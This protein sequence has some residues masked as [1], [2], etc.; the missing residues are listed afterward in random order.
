MPWLPLTRQWMQQLVRRERTEQLA[1]GKRR[2]HRP[3]GQLKGQEGQGGKEDHQTSPSRASRLRAGNISWSNCPTDRRGRP[4]P[5]KPKKK[6]TASDTLRA[7]RTHI[8]VEAAKR[9]TAPHGIHRP[10][11]AMTRTAQR[12]RNR[13]RTGLRADAGGWAVGTHFVRTGQLLLLERMRSFSLWV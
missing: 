13:P 3:Q 2:C 12:T 1:E 9:I 4:L 5:R 8:P 6:T 11:L 10:Y 7:A